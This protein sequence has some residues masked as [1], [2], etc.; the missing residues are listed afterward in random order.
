MLG[1]GSLEYRIRIRCERYQAEVGRH[2]AQCHHICKACMS[3]YY[4]QSSH[5]VLGAHLVFA[6]YCLVHGYAY[7]PISWVSLFFSSSVCVENP[8]EI[9]KAM[10][11]DHGIDGRVI[12]IMLV[13]RFDSMCMAECMRVMLLA[14]IVS[15]YSN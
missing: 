2:H 10:L 7:F 8:G 1:V 6:R 13:W 4:P 15:E 14:Q 5:L 11:T 9:T 3:M 12:H